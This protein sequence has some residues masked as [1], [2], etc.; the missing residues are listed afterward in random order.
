MSA[1]N[2]F[3]NG[4]I[5]ISGSSAFQIDGVDPQQ[6]DFGTEVTLLYAAGAVDPT[7]AAVLKVQPKISFTATDIKAMLDAGIWIDGFAIPQ[8]TVYTTVDLYATK[9]V[10]SS[11]RAT[12]TNQMRYRVTT[13]VIIPRTLTVQQGQAAKLACDII[14]VYDGTNAVIIPATGVA[15]PATPVIDECWTLGPALF[16]GTEFDG[17]QG[18]TLNF[19][20]EEEII[21]ANGIVY[22]VRVHIK[23]RKPMF[24]FDLKDESSVATHGIN[25]VPQGATDSVFWLRKVVDNSVTT[26]E[27]QAEHISLTVDDG[28]LTVGQWG[29]GND[30]SH[31]G[32][33]TY[34]PKF[35]GTNAVIVKDTAAAISA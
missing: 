21:Y 5:R 24:E 31:S 34:T 6:V 13:G 27:D 8:S 11:I 22:P 20:I 28:I 7:R 19:G 3:F 30:A 23:R 10:E 2:I 17:L 14:P 4:P 25:G 35:D 15:L 26:A 29:G 18:W 1:N 9:S 16:N 32:K 12:S 33:L